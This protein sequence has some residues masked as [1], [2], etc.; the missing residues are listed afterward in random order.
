ME[1]R[2]DPSAPVGAR[3]RVLEGDEVVSLLDVAI[4]GPVARLAVDVVGI[5]DVDT[6]REL[7]DCALEHVELGTASTLRL[8]TSDDL[9]RRRAR[10]LGFRAP[11]RGALERSLLGAAPVSA[12]TES[13][14]D[15]AQVV[16]VV[17][18]LLPGVDVAAAGGLFR[19]FELRA[20]FDADAQVKARLPRRGDLMAEP[21]AAAIDTVRAIKA[22][23]G[24]AASGIRKV[25][26]DHGGQAL[27]TGD[28]AGM[29]EG[30]SG[31]VVLTPNFASA[32]LLADE[33]RFRADM[34]R[35]V[36]PS[37]ANARPCWV[38]D[39]VVA[40]ECWHYLDAEVR[41]SGTTYV[42][43]N[44]ALGDA[45]GVPSLEHAL[46]GRDPGSPSE[47]R[48]AHATLVR[49]VSAYAGTNPREAT[50]EMFKLWWADPQYPSPVVARFGE[51]VERHFPV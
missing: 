26:F 29:A 28:I 42:E 35:P 19:A 11:L 13:L 20:R 6:A 49:E 50:A 40:H 27:A 8:V 18:A 3:D 23:F 12:T 45:L 17:G 48:A 36:R 43:F 14:D 1:V 37:P 46:R 31:V 5:V 33:R 25:S 16:S 2:H 24:P 38:L 30:A 44:A 32:G 9:L 10:H 41:V 15:L 51:L 47:W 39:G 7:L 22:R 4:E 21:I 34:G